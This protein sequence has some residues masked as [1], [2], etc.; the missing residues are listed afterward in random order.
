MMKIWGRANSIN[1]QK[2]L[3]ACDEL[4]VAFERIDAGMQFGVTNT[5]AFLA[6]N[7]NGL[8]PV[9]EHDGFT[10]W[11]SHA[12]VRYLARMQGLGSLCPADPRLAAVADQWMDWAA[13][14]L[15]PPMKPVFINLV[16]VPPAD[17]DHSAVAQGVQ[18]L[19]SAFT[20]LDA[21]LASHPYVAGDDFTMGDM[22]L[23]VIAYRWFELEIERKDFHHLKRWYDQVTSRPGF[24]RHCAVKLT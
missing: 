24:Q 5:P 1:V 23:A 18:A 7:P 12:I 13:T 8:V 2:V 16:R 3:W 17:R 15:W 10:L 6:I 20:I 19:T 22:A 9:L 21:H 14:T 11:E 4:G